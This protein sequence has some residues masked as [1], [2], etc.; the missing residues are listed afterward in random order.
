[1]SRLNRY[2]AREEGLPELDIKPLAFWGQRRLQSNKTPEFQPA[3]GDASSQC[4]VSGRNSQSASQRSKLLNGFNRGLWLGSRGPSTM[5]SRV[6]VDAK[7]P[8]NV[9]VI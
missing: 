6:W 4:I 7:R 5:T 1:M 9:P 3:I 8:V 2:Y